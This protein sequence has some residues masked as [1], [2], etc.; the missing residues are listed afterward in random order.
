MEGV[1]LER[2]AL[3]QCRVVEVLTGVA[4]HP[5]P[6]HDRLGRLVGNGGEGHDFVEAERGESVLDRHRAA[7]DGGRPGLFAAPTAAWSAPARA[8]R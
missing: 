2:M 5:D 1:P 7:I 6:P 8:A 4:V 3:L